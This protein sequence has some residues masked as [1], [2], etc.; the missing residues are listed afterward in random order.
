MGNT[1]R[2]SDDWKRL[3]KLDKQM[4]PPASP[5]RNWLKKLSADVNAPPVA[6][7]EAVTYFLKGLRS[8]IVRNS[9]K[10]VACALALAC[11]NHG[12]DRVKEISDAVRVKPMDLVNGVHS[13]A[14]GLGLT[15]KETNISRELMNDLQALGLT[16]EDYVEIST[17][18]AAV[19]KRY[20]SSA[21]I[22]T[23]FAAVTYGLH[24]TTLTQRQ[25]ADAF[26]VDEYTLR[27][28]WIAKVK[29]YMDSLR[30]KTV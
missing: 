5:L 30:A 16:Q 24:S 7:D 18:V 2:M 4:G 19:A 27:S 29:P 20:P 25:A 21:R 15:V 9:K 14:D 17:H 11:R 28:Q 12:A 1:A 6:I 23:L 8:G 13:L 26:G 3:A 10:W 22:R